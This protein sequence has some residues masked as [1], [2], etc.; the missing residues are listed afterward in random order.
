MKQVAAPPGQL[1]LDLV[2][3][4]E[5]DIAAIHQATGVYTAPPEIEDLL[6]QLKWP[7]QGQRLLDPGAGNGGFLVAALN[8]LPLRHDDAGEAARRVRGYE[9]HAAAAAEARQAIRDHLA[10]RGWTAGAAGQA[11]RAIVE[12]DDFLL[13]D[14]SPGQWDVIAANPPYLRLASLPAA[15]RADYEPAVPPDA[16]A[17]LLYAY[18]S[19]AAEVIAPGGRLGMITADRWLLNKG[20]AKLR[21][22]LGKVYS[23]AGVRRLN[24][25][26][27][28]YRSKQRR[29]G[30]LARVHPVSL[31]LVPGRGGRR[32]GAEPFRLAALPDIDG[33]PLPE[34]ASI[35]LAPWLGPDGIFI[36]SSRAGLPGDQLVPVV[37]PEDIDG[38]SLRPARK[39]ALLTGRAEPPAA[40]LAHLD[41]NLHRMPPG[42]RRTPRWLP[43][44]TF[45]GRLPLDR[46]AVLVPRIAR[47]LRGILLP[48]GRMP[49]NHSLVV[50][51]GAI[52]ARAMIAM[53]DDPA[54]QAWA[55]ALALGVDNDYKSYTASL[56]RELVIP[57]QYLAGLHA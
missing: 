14:V 24:P 17:D 7:A 22:R 21:S 30:A 57:R 27:A 38:D 51:S 16:R 56:L 54:V 28:F 42:G 50:L 53:L 31:V 33:V 26:S 37:E 1:A 19:R 2:S 12:E 4:R 40:V 15:Y 46:D 11:A 9:F 34:I 55:D 32:L 36:V 47:R 8:R 20:S 29:K 52:P 18:L 44:E 49:V 3:Q 25:E 43:P 41:R 45:A 10:G 35:R 13:S 6:D 5:L 48:A 39:W 23:V